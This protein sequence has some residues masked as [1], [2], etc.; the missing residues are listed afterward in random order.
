MAEDIRVVELFAGVGG[1]RVGL[2]AASPRFKT[3]WA[4][5]WEPGR[6]SQHAYDC[7][8]HHFG[9][10]PNH[11]NTDI[12]LAVDEVP[13]HDLLVGGFPCQDYSVA[14]TNAK[15]IEGKK[16]VLW[17]QINNILTRVRP[18][19]VLLENVDRLIKSP[20]RQR[21]RDFAVILKCLA[22]LGYAVEWRVVNA[23]EY[24]Y[25]QRRRR[26]FIF[27]QHE[28]TDICRNNALSSARQVIFENGFFAQT[29]PVQP[30][31]QEK[32]FDADIELPANILDVSR[33]FSYRFKNAGY[34]RNGVITTCEVVPVK[35]E[36][37]PLLSILQ[38]E[39]RDE[40]YYNINL[41]KVLYY[42]GS[43]RE[44]RRKPNGVTYHY[45]E[46]AV[47]F[48]DNLTAPARTIL[49]S[50]SKVNRSTHYILDP[51]TGRI[52][53]LTPVECE[54]INGFPDDWTNTGM[55]EAYRYFT[56]GNALVV[57]LIT[58]MGTN[59]TKLL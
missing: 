31:S 23:A 39:V 56:M 12:S 59:L 14:A 54:R 21:G 47:P 25:A 6:K 57:P 10:T 32:L 51:E 40:R 5:Q 36:P 43:K 8:V 52:R 26:V 37:T 44:E 11:S 18:P 55:P 49:T 42:K 33:D 41:E 3:V 24:G 29:F 22:L 17:W 45:T 4:N 2:E 27:A 28:S 38:T 1:F 9:M 35:M 7:Y 58:R 19:Y 20:A 34:M 30:I 15:G 48:P 50:E 13:D 46:G 53:T 16:G